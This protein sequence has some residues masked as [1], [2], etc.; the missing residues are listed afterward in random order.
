MRDKIYRRKFRKEFGKEFRKEFRKGSLTVEASLVCPFF[1][2]AVMAL[3]YIIMW[4]ETAAGIQAELADK[5]RYAADMSVT[6]YDN[7]SADEAE[8]IVITKSYKIPH[9]PVG[10]NQKVVTRPYVGV[11]SINTDKEDIIVYVT[12]NGTVYHTNRGCTYIKVT[13]S[14]VRGDELVLLRNKSGGRY[15]PCEVCMKDKAEPSEDVYVTEYGDRY[16]STVRCNRIE[17]NV[18]AIRMSEVSDMRGCSKCTAEG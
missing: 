14:K 9:L 4:F 10:V 11:N 5:A 2:I 7:E 16:H 13:C 12:R 18:I 15:K 17:R 1:I 3:V 8:D 6:L